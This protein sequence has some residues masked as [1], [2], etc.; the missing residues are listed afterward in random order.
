MGRNTSA[1][2]G[3]FVSSI[4]YGIVWVCCLI[5]YW[6]SVAFGIPD[7][8]WIMGHTLVALY[9]ALPLASVIASFFIGRES[10]FGWRRLLAPI[11]AGLFYALFTAATFSLSTALGL[12]NIASPNLAAL[13]SD[14]PPQRLVSSSVGSLPQ[15]KKTLRCGTEHNRHR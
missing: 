14:S 6:I 8:S 11:A 3:I 7:G 5:W 1:T 15:K 9:L 12:A 2:R 13:F 4:I 10:G